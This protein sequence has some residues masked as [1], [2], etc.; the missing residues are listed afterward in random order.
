MNEC[1]DHDNP[2]YYPDPYSETYCDNSEHPYEST[3]TVTY[4]CDETQYY[5]AYG[6]TEPTNDN[7]LRNQPH[8]STSTDSEQN[9]LKV[10][11]SRKSK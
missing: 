9:F 5:E 2:M 11:P 10:W 1:S 6:L 3:T 4:E 7:N 8:P